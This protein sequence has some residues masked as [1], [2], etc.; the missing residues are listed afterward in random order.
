M[1]NVV[2]SGTATGAAGSKENSVSTSNVVLPS[3]S[4]LAPSGAKAAVKLP[5]AASAPPAKGSSNF[6]AKATKKRI[7]SSALRIIKKTP[8]GDRQLPWSEV[9]DHVPSPENMGVLMEGYR[10]ATNSSRMV[11][12]EL[13]GSEVHEWLVFPSPIDGIKFSGRLK[14]IPAF[15]MKPP[16]FKCTVAFV[17][18]EIKLEKKT[19]HLT[20][21]VRTGVKSAY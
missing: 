12:Y 9:H 13:S 18:A 2:S 4:S 16:S 20:V 17:K 6:N 7:M 10:P 1:S 15:G 3:S 5:A 14:Y 19:G 8:H 11:K 21:K